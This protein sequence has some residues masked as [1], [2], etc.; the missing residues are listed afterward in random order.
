MGYNTKI[1]WCDATWN[2]VTGCLHGCEYCYARIIAERFKG[3][4]DFKAKG[5]ADP[6]TWVCDDPGRMNDG[7][8]AVYP[9]G[10]DPTLHRYRLDEPAQWKKSRNI[11]VCSMADLFG[12]WVP[13]EWIAEVF[14]ACEKAPQHRYLFLTKYPARYIALAEKDLLPDNNHMWFGSTATTPETEFFFSEQHNTFL[15]VEPILKPFC[16]SLDTGIQACEK[17]DWIIIGAETGRRKDKVIPKA[18]WIIELVQCAEET[19]TPVFMKDSLRKI[20][21]K[22]F[23]QD[24]PWE[25]Q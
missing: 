9:F 15:S 24:F 4:Y 2:P 25:V 23:R 6:L 8:K 19:N 1:D 7:R 3:G 21:G 12:K 5:C 18:S 22:A 14:K 20:M 13:D 10:F 17:T 11:F 16:D